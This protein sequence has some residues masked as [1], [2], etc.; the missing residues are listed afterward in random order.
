MIGNKLKA[1]FKI[2]T[3]CGF[4]IFAYLLFAFMISCAPA[5]Y[6]PENSYLLHKN[7]LIVEQNKIDKSKLEAYILQKPNKRI[8]GIRLN[9]FYYNLSNIDKTRWP[10]SWLRRIGEE[11]VIYDPFLTARTHDQLKIYLEN[12]GFYDAQVTDSVRFNKKNAKVRYEITPGEPLRD[13][14]TYET[15]SFLFGI[16]KRP[17]SEN[18]YH[19]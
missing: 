6:V 2:S 12:R 7:K 17:A 1:N 16:I 5:R 15:P 4:H 10:H 14:M 8:L 11:P 3:R 13:K 18:I 19:N 9:L